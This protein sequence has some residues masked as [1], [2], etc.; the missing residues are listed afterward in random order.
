MLNSNLVELNILDSKKIR[1][2]IVFEIFV[3]VNK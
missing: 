2:I 3:V 1:N